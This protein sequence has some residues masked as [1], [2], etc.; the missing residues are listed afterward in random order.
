MPTPPAILNKIKLLRKLAT[1]PNPHE[2]ES[3]QRLADGLIEK[4]GVTPEEIAALDPKPL[5]GDNDKLYTTIGIV[6]WRQQLA[7]SV[8]N[9]LECQ[10]VQ[11]ELVPTEGEHPY[12]YYVYGEP[13][14]VKNV[15]FAFRVFA[16]KVELLSDTQCLG[17][18][19]VYV[20]SYCE[21][22]VDAIKQNII[23]FGIDLPEIKKPVKKVEP[24]AI[25]T[26]SEEITKPKP[27]A[28]EKH[29]DVGT[30]SKIQDIMAYFRGIQDGKDLFLEDILEITAQNEVAQ[31]LP[32]ENKVENET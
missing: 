7:V 26:K 28:A 19:P 8:A 10:I 18:G 14:D 1:S 11:V 32:E 12:E 25:T 27:E 21:G 9:H 23:L 15:Q 5:Y 31:K 20:G 6:G 3:A 22:V 16:K 2:A 24:E 13:D 17:R 30:Q 4:H 29:I